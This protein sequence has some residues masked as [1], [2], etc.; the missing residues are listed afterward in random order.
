MMSNSLENIPTEEFVL[1]SLDRCRRYITEIIYHCTDDENNLDLMKAGYHI[2]VTQQTI[3]DACLG[4]S[5]IKHSNYEDVLSDLRCAISYLESSIES[6]TDEE[7]GEIQVLKIGYFMGLTDARLEASIKNL[8]NT[9]IGKS[10][11]TAINIYD[12]KLE[13][14]MKTYNKSDIQLRPQWKETL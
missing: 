3:S 12:E 4:L 9:F 7:T 1:S 2:G 8:S 10:P 13:K 11:D 14:T 5:V 6:T